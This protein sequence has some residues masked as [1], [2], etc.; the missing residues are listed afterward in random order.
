MT[1][2]LILRQQVMQRALERC[3]YCHLPENAGFASHEIDHIIAQK[4]GG[5]TVLSNLALSCILCN[6]HKGSDL[7]SIDPTTNQLVRL[8]HPRNDQ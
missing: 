8:F 3:E 2:S 1:I 4:H 5:Q 6:K 7:A